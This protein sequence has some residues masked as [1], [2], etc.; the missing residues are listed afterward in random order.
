MAQWIRR[1]PTEQEILGSSPG[2]VKCFCFH[3]GCKFIVNVICSVDGRL[4]TFMETKT[5]NQCELSGN[6]FLHILSLKIWMS[7]E[8]ISHQIFMNIVKVDL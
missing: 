2:R 6:S 1:L 5:A 8:F 7:L 3:T 4:S